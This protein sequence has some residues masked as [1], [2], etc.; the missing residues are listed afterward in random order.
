VREEVYKELVQLQQAR[1]PFA[2]MENVFY[3]STD[4]LTRVRVDLDVDLPT[5][6]AAIFQPYLADFIDTLY[7]VLYEYT[8]L[9]LETEL[10][11]T[12][13][14][15]EKPR[16]TARDGSGFKHGAKLTM[17]YLVATHTDMLQLRVLLLQHADRWMPPSWLGDTPVLEIIDPCVY[18][19]NGW[20]MYGS[21]KKEQVHGGYKAT[22][23]WH[24]KGDAGPVADCDWTL[25]ELHRL[26]SIFCDHETDDAV[27]TLDW[28]KAPPEV[29]QR[30]RKRQRNASAA[31]TVREHADV[32][33]PVLSILTQILAELGD[34][35]SVLTHESTSEDMYRYRVNRHG[36]PAP[37]ASKQ[38]HT[39]NCSI[40]QLT[41]LFGRPVVKYIFFSEKC[42]GGRTP[43]VLKCSKLAKRWTEAEIVHKRQKPDFTGE[44]CHDTGD[45]DIACTAANQPECCAGAVPSVPEENDWFVQGSMVEEPEWYADDVPSSLYSLRTS[46]ISRSQI[47]S[48]QLCKKQQ[49]LHWRPRV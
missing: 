43:V 33:A 18:K 44:E 30:G 15:L 20:L 19:S 5:D 11:G 6:D 12:I 9:T 23:V 41:T 21:R 26:L 36:R 34:K 2:I 1:V 32:T 46:M 24:C 22:R 4:A 17:P 29:E 3:L 40:L 49:Q 10:A 35:T 39:S 45:S 14:L 38:E 37:C 28:I 31:S 27:Q 48:E 7:D 13:I 8:E 42:G 16:C 47:R 25:L